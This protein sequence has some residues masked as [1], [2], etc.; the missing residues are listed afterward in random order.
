LE[1]KRE[2]HSIRYMDVAER[3]TGKGMFR[4]AKET[5]RLDERDVVMRWLAELG[6]HPDQQVF[7]HR[8]WGTIVAVAQRQDPVGVFWTDGGTTWY[9]VPPGAV[10]DDHLT[11]EQVK[12]VMLE[13]LTSPGPPE[14]PQW[15]TLI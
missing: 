11:P 8:D 4:T 3:L 6:S 7:V 13:A 10:G 1:R 12:H 15:R 9:A 2:A 14:W 5:A